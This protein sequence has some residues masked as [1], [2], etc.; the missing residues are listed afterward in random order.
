MIFEEVFTFLLKMVVCIQ[1][2]LRLRYRCSS[3]FFLVK[4][5]VNF[6]TGVLKRQAI[7]MSTWTEGV[8]I[9]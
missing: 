2:F 4:S 5:H 6:F 7:S 3:V 1:Y 8:V 9:F